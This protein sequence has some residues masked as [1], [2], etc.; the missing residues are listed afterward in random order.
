MD[1]EKELD[2]GRSE[3]SQPSSADEVQRPTKKSR[4]TSRSKSAESDEVSA[5]IN[6][7]EI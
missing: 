4:I 1:S 2:K 7:A 5:R 3:S 6:M